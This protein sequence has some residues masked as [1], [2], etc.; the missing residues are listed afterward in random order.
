MPDR[1]RMRRSISD[2]PGLDLY[3]RDA[4]GVGCGLLGRL[5]N[6]TMTPPWLLTAF[7]EVGTHEVP[8]P[9]A[10]PRIVQYAATTTL[11]AT[12]D[13]VPWCSSFVNWCLTKNGLVGTNSAA[14]R[15]WLT[16]GIASL[17]KLGAV[18]VFR[19]G[20]AVAPGPGFYAPGHVAFFVY[21]DGNQLICLG[22]NQ[23]DAVSLSAFPESRLIGYRWPR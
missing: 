13:E 3:V 11:A 14:A 22:G 7:G 10:E 5:D 17:P 19:R 15:S 1:G 8:G 12:S 20:P 9:G 23:K 2:R 16:W 6:P 18:A 21:A 4:R